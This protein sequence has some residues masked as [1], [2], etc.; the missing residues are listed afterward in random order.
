MFGLEPAGVDLL[1]LTEDV[2][3]E[4]VRGESGAASSWRDRAF[5]GG[6]QDSCVIGAC[7]ARGD[8]EGVLVRVDPAQ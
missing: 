1:V 2:A 4:G 8:D 3:G 5:R 6:Q 7:D